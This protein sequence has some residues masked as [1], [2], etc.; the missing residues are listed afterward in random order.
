[1]TGHALVCQGDSFGFDP[2]LARKPLDSVNR[3]MI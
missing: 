2:V 3:D 1:M